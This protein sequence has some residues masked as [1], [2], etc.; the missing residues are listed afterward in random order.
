MLSLRRQRVGGCGVLLTRRQRVGGC[1]AGV[2]ATRRQQMGGCCRIALP[3]TEH[4]P[5]AF[6]VVAAVKKNVSQVD[7]LLCYHRG[8]TDYIGEKLSCKASALVR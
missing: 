4:G 6:Y 8:A 2:L 5:N 1:S 7:F 3:G